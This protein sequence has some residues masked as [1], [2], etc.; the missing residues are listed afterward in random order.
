MA[1]K[2]FNEYYE[3]VCSDY[4]K[5]LNELKDMEK[6]YAEGVVSPDMLEQLKQIVEPIKVN[7]Q[8]LEYVQYLLNKPLDDKKSDKY[9]AKNIAVLE[10]CRD[11]E[12]V[13]QEN[14]QCI[15]Q[16]KMVFEEDNK[17]DVN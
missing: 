10:S 9:A 1:K 14:A 17:N 7:W 12:T 15:E 2:H 3:K 11:E 6:Y 4:Y 8:T 16:L 13:L 5:M